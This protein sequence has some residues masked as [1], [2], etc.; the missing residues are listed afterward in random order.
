MYNYK[1]SFDKIRTELAKF[2][3]PPN[4]VKVYIFLGKYG[5]KTAP[6]VSNALKI[7]RTEAYHILSVLQN[8]GI[9]SATFDHPIQFSAIP[10]DRAIMIMVNAE[11]ERLKIL[12]IQKTEIVELWNSIPTFKLNTNEINQEGKFQILKGTNTMISKINTLIESAKKNFFMLGSEKD[13]VRL[14]HSDCLEN[15]RD[16]KIDIRFI[17][18][19]SKNFAH[20]LEEMPNAMIKK[21]PNM[22][23]NNLCFITKD[24]DELLLFASNEKQSMQD[25]VAIWTTSAS[26]V[27]A[28]SLLFNY[29]WSNSKFV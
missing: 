17:A 10:L 9:V 16:S 2:G 12:E 21:I 18:P 11:K 27:Y 4:Q 8:K 6:E 23:K 28:M 22:I 14:Y 5:P 25:T 19:D 15:L 29:V 24:D 26:M 7:Q 20:V 1:L 3:M 13:F